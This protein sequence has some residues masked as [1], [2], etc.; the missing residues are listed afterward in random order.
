MDNELWRKYYEDQGKVLASKQITYEYWL[1][2]QLKEKD[3]VISEYHTK[4][5]ADKESYFEVV[6]AHDDLESKNKDLIESIESLLILIDSRLGLMDAETI[7][8][9]KSHIWNKVVTTA[10]ELVKQSKS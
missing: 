3:I 2:S 6:E 8:K 10:Q 9:G 1:E 5:L 4:M 7:G